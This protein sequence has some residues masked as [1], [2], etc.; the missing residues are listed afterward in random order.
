MKQNPPPGLH[1]KLVQYHT[2]I[3]PNYL[4]EDKSRQLL[5]G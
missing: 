5:I 1:V 4:Q 2:S 3:E